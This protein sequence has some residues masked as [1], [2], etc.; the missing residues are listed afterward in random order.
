MI[1]EPKSLPKKESHNH[2]KYYIKRSPT[3]GNGNV[4]SHDQEVSKL[5][6]T[7]NANSS[8]IQVSNTFTI[9]ELIVEST[10]ELINDPNY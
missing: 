7:N 9:I 3:H 8:Y 4:Q 1:A 6:S 5:N 2:N 10:M